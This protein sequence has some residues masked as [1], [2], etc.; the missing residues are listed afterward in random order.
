MC[1]R[2]G[3]LELL[4]LLSYGTTDSTVNTVHL[5][6]LLR[7]GVQAV[8]R[9]SIRAAERRQRPELTSQV[10]TCTRS[11]T[12]L[13]GR[14]YW[15]DTLTRYDERRGAVEGVM[16]ELSTCPQQPGAGPKQT[17]MPAAL[18]DGL[19]ENS[20]RERPGALGTPLHDIFNR[21]GHHDHVQP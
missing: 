2:T 7:S 21:L 3:L 13:F 14:I 18:R 20:A 17:P 6:V 12:P 11:E 15:A 5:L 10:E 16:S 19:E 1:P 9:P 4:V 8:L